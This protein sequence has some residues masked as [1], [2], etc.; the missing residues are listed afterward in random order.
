M[1]EMVSLQIKREEDTRWPIDCI[2]KELDEYSE[3]VIIAKKKEGN[4]YTKFHGKLKD[5]F[6]WI[7]VLER[8]KLMLSFDG[9]I[10]PDE[11]E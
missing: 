3:I 11:E 2:L 5:T 8:V 7:G 10:E 6:W 4:V 9:T 1:G